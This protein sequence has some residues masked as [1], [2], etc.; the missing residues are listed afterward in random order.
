MQ[1]PSRGRGEVTL[2]KLCACSHDINF[3]AVWSKVFTL[4]I[5]C[6]SA[7]EPASVHVVGVHVMKAMV[8]DTVISALMQR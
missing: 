7:L 2:S 6:S 1:G 8:G 3:Y 4:L 5:H